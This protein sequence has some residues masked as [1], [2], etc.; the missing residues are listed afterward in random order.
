VVNKLNLK[1]LVNESADNASEPYDNTLYV[2]LKLHEETLNKLT[3]IGND[4]SKSGKELIKRGGDLDRKIYEVNMEVINRLG[5]AYHMLKDFEKEKDRI[6][7][8]IFNNKNK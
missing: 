6:S 1:S 4:L 2:A 7:K 5:T 3:T 8:A